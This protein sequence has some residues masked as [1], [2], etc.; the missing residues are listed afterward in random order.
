MTKTLGD[1]DWDTLIR[2]VDD[3]KC[4]P[5]LGAGACFGAV[6]LGRDI[7]RDWATK[8]GYP[9]DDCDD[10]VR[11]A[12][13]LAVDRGAMF[14]KDEIARLFKSLELPD[15]N[16]PDE[17]H[18]VLADLPLPVYMTTNY[19]DI[20]ISALKDRK[21]DPKRELCRWNRA[22]G[23]EPSVFEPGF[24]PTPAN[25]VVFHLHGHH[26]LVESLVL[27]EDDYLAF[28]VKNSKD[29]EILPHW[30]QRVL[31]GTS[32]LFI[33][34]R[35]VDWSF[36]VLFRQ[37][38]MSR[39]DSL[40]RM[41]VTVQLPS[42]KQTDEVRLKNG[43]KITGKVIKQS[44]G[45]IDIETDAM[46]VLS[47]DSRFVD[48]LAAGEDREEAQRKQQEYLSEY[49]ERMNMRVYWG[50]AREFARELRERW[51]KYKLKEKD[52]KNDA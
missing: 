18:G 46:G 10:L 40:R 42:P 6:P 8:Y 12:Q 36:R 19:D 22:Y 32:L 9:L 47:I 3:G 28:L 20:M 24:T 26:K 21:K 27:T 29:E 11:V 16:E 44:E 52:S 31:S 39:E 4:T 51:E 7:A 49:F 43:D 35:L 23:Y 34:Y 15:F 38:V 13:F 50:D 45:N 2:A 25:P 1:K 14:P 33:G 37:F 17:P 41:G 30:I 48:C 5:F